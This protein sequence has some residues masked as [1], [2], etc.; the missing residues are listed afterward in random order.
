V[1][2]VL[3]RLTHAIMRDV[4]VVA[5]TAERIAAAFDTAIRTDCSTT[6]GALRDGRLAAGHRLLAVRGVFMYRRDSH[7]FTHRQQKVYE[8]FC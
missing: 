3:D 8:V 6:V 4:I 5:L 7:F 1:A 2:F